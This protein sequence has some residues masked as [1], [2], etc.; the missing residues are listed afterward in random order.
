[1]EISELY[2]LFL[3]SRGVNTD[4][5]T[6]EPG[7]VFVALKGETF[8]GNAYLVPFIK[9]GIMITRIFWSSGMCLVNRG[10]KLPRT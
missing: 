2:T 7:Q 5:R 6:L 4:T 10:R 1:M 3:A 9:S 8:D